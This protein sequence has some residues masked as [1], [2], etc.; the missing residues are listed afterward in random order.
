M[1]RLSEVISNPNTTTVP[2]LN[3]DD[4]YQRTVMY[5]NGGEFNVDYGYSRE[6]Q[7]K[8]SVDRDIPG[9]WNTSESITVYGVTDADGN[10]VDYD[11]ETLIQFICQRIS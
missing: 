1:S 7:Y 2:N 11:E 9:H 4:G 8:E 5:I 10:P 3:D 6:S